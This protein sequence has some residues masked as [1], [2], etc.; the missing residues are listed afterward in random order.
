KMK[1]MGIT[2]PANIQKLADTTKQAS[3]FFNDLGKEI[4]TTAAGFIS[5]QAIIGAVETGFRD[6]AGF[7]GDSIASYAAAET[8]TKKM[9]VALEAQGTATQE[10]I[11]A[12]NA[13]ATSFQQTTTYS[14]DLITEMEALLT[15]VGNV[16]PS[17][18]QKAL[19][20]STD[21]AAGLGIDLRQATELVAKA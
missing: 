20:A 13:L 19:K 9:A 15:E 16:A 3:G 1:A 17:E 18:M 21:L 7:V 10:N 6:L 4:A 12:N 14:D 8:A 2:V 11:A 5:A